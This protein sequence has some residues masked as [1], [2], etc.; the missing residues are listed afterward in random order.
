MHY[1]TTYTLARASRAQEISSYP[2]V[3][4]KHAAGTAAALALPSGREGRAVRRTRDVY[5]HSYHH[6]GRT[7]RF[8]QDLRRLA[9]VARARLGRM[10]TEHWAIFAVGLVAGLLLG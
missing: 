9:D 10:T 7:S 3:A 4:E 5:R 8:A 2:G 6:T 1:F